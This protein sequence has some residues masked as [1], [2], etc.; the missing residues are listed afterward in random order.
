[1]IADEDVGI[2]RG[3]SGKGS[4]H[5]GDGF[6]HPAVGRIAANLRVGVELEGKKEIG[7]MRAVRGP[8]GLS[9][10][11]SPCGAAQHTQKPAPDFPAGALGAVCL[12]VPEK[13]PEKDGSRI[14]GDGPPCLDGLG[15]ADFPAS[16][17]SGHRAASSAMP[18][19]E[20]GREE[21]PFTPPCSIVI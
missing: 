3:A 16:G 14:M 18:S 20:S 9:G 8:K 12:K 17:T 2:R 4:Q 21:R 13:R 11:L 5:A 15:I 10:T 7:R 6:L 1:M 19:L